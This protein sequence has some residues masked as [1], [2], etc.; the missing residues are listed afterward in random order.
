[1]FSF[2]TGYPEAGSM[3]TQPCG[4]CRHANQETDDAAEGLW[5][6]PWIGAV[7]QAGACR[8]RYVDGGAPAF[9]PYDGRNGTWGSAGGPYRAVPAGYERRSV[10]VDGRTG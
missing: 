5:A 8:V 6:C 10:V 2:Q 1:L 9:E 7:D 3:T 4:S